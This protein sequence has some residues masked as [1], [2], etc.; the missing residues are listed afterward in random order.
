VREPTQ[1]CRGYTDE[2]WKRLRPKLDVDPPDANAWNEAITVFECRIRERF[3][4]S[5]DAL[6]RADSGPATDVKTGSDPSLPHDAGQAVVPGFAIMALCSLLI[7]TLQAF[8]EGPT[9]GER[10]LFKPFLRLPAFC[11]QLVEKLQ[12]LRERP[13]GG[14]RD[15]FK[16]FLR[17]PA[18]GI[19]FVNDA[20]ASAFVGGIRNGIFHEAETRRWAIRRTEP[21]GKLVE[22]DGDGYVL[23]RTAFC[24]ALKIEFDGYLA[25][26]RDASK[27]DRR[28]RFLEKMDGIVKK[29]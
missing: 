16:P 8:R 6:E 3:L 11:S 13:T 22:R 4:T 20:V 24:V 23:N 27:G 28:R 7:E 26:L 19:A 12:R 1:I 29:R 5:I 15:P 14:K 2:H 25:E 21:M 17:L 9:G 10:D 18:F